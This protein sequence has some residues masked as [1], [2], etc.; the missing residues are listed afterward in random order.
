MNNTLGDYVAFFDQQV[1]RLAELGISVQACRVSHLA[2]RTSSFDEYLSVRQDL[3]ARC[4]ANVENVWNGRPISKILL[5]EPLRLSAAHRVSLIE[6]IPPPHQADYKMGLEH[7]GF[8][9]DEGFADFEKTFRAAFT[10]RQFQTEDCQPYFIR[11]A[12][13]TN[14]KFYPR[15]LQEYCESEG[16]CFDGIHRHHGA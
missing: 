9:L 15:T 11:F 8:A 10:G 12:D 1:A 5:A 4:S 2:F 14:V 6:L 13:R 16:R 7:V 3:E